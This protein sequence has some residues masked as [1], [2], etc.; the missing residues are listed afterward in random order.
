[1]R[2]ELRAKWNGNY[3]SLVLKFGSLW[4]LFEE[5]TQNKTT[6]AQEILQRIAPEALEA[7]K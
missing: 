1:M 2:T 5:K 3:D 6:R 7:F 4:G